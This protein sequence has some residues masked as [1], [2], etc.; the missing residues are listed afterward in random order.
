METGVASH[1]SAFVMNPMEHALLSRIALATGADYAAHPDSYDADVSWKQAL[2]EQYGPLHE[3]MQIFAEHS[4]RM[5]TSW[6]HTGRNDAPAIRKHMDEVWEALKAGRNIHK[7]CTILRKDFMRMETAAAKLKSEL[8][9]EKLAE[10]QPQLTLLKELANA[11][12]TMLCLIQAKQNGQNHAAA[13]LSRLL[14][15]EV[16]ALP[17]PD[18]ALLSE[19]TSAA[20]LKEGK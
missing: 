19:K 18:Q 5:D 20:F 16:Q 14:A 8:P 9:K 2:Q 4:Q 13:V 3:D 1:M 11:D 17:T 15:R 12:Q 10:C 6:A 7:E